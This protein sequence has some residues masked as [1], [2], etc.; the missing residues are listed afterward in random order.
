MQTF[1]DLVANVIANMI[2]NRAIYC[3]YVKK[4]FSF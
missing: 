1:E 3:I 2:R 4:Y